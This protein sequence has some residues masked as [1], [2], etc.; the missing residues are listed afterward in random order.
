MERG[1]VDIPQDHSN[2]Y[3]TRS[4]GKHSVNIDLPACPRFISRVFPSAKPLETF[5]KFNTTQYTITKT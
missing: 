1:R 4:S 2:Q 5:H 3:N